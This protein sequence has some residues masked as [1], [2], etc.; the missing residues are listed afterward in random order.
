M[1]DW[2]NV[3]RKEDLL[4]GD[5]VVVDIDDV[6]IAVFNINGDILAVEDICSHDGGELASGE[7]EGDAIICP[8]HGAKFCLRTGAVLAAPAYEPIAV[9]PVRI[10]N[11]MVQAR[12]DRWD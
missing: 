1:S 9:F 11:D 8:R 7:L 2:V 5:K 6:E 3:V 10:D 12:D 4:P